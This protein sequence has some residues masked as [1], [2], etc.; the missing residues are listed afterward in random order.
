MNMI[1]Q[2]DLVYF[3][4]RTIIVGDRIN[5]LLST[6]DRKHQ[7]ISY[8]PSKCKI[9]PIHPRCYLTQ[10]VPVCLR[11]HRSVGLLY[12]STTCDSVP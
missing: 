7:T 2:Y 12:Y 1:I 3:I 11:S 8:I 5:H 9:H 4:V 6:S 10:E